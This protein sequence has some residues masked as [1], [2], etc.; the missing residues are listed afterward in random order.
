MKDRDTHYRLLQHRSMACTFDAGVPGFCEELSPETPFADFTG[1][2]VS[3]AKAAGHYVE[4]ERPEVFGDDIEQSFFFT[5]GQQGKVKG[6]IFESLCCAVLWN[7]CCYLSGTYSGYIDPKIAELLS[8]VR[9][10]YPVSAIT[11]GD[12]YPLSKLFTPEASA[13]FLEF[14]RALLE[15][16]TSLCYSTPDLIVFRVKDEEL[17]ALLTDPIGNITESTIRT[18]AGVKNIVAGRLTPSDILLAS[19]LKTSIRSDRMYQFLFE[20]NAWKAIWRKVYG[21]KPSKYHSVMLGH[22]GAN[23]EKLRSVEFT[24]IGEGT[25]EVEKAIDGFVSIQTPL[26]LVE[27]FVGA[28]EDLD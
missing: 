15:R 16:G 24:S 23:R 19:G 12:N 10:P 8:A 7:S 11:L 25:S 1:Q 18:L 9:T 2:C 27:W 20:A 3:N 14:E 6:D 21:L 13:Q 26:D 17:N 5:P 28:I 22:Y 4:A